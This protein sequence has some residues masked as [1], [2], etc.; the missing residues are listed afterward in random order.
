MLCCPSF[1]TSSHDLVLVLLALHMLVALEIAVSL[2][3][4]ASYKFNETL[5]SIHTAIPWPAFNQSDC[6]STGGIN[7]LRHKYFVQT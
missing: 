2:T 6:S 1:S 5:D 7:G 3:R 4:L